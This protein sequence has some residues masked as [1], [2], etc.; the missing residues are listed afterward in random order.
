MR[1]L[2]VLVVVLLLLAL[3]GWITFNSGPD[4]SSINLETNEIKEDTHDA[5]QSGADLLDEVGNE[6]DPSNSPADSSLPAEP[7]PAR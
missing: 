6:I 2:I 5:I 3:A 1:A 4:R 7:A